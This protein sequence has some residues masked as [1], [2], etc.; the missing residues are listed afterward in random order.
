MRIKTYAIV[1]AVAVS[2]MTLPAMARTVVDFARSA[3][4]VDGRS[5]VGAAADA[6]SRA[7][8]LVATDQ[9]GRLPNDI[10]KKAPDS[11]RLGGRT[12][13][14]YLT[15]CDSGVV[16]GT[17]V[18]PSDV[19]PEYAP[20]EGYQYVRALGECQTQSV[21]AR[22]LSTGIY[23]IAF[24]S[25]ITC[26]GESEAPRSL[27]T[28]ATVKSEIPLVLSTHTTCDLNGWIVE[29]V[30]VVDMNG[31]PRDATFTIALLGHTAALP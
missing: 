5:A 3:G 15:T 20:V 25:G 1:L 28:V 24:Q 18:V 9:R 21:E 17:A 22:R 14:S 11:R 6:D 7:G 26:A 12:A 19:G 2:A 23:Q 30:R 10:I 27:P 13:S 8:K 16:V 29:E 4:N 31:V